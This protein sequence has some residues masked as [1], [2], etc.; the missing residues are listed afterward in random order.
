MISNDTKPLDT[1]LFQPFGLNSRCGTYPVLPRE[2]SRGYRF[3]LHIAGD[4]PKQGMHP[5]LQGTV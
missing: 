1:S 3:R 4:M 2:T 5:K